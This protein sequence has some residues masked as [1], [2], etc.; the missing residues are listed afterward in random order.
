MLLTF[1]YHRMG[2]VKQRTLSFCKNKHDQGTPRLL[3]KIFQNYAEIL[4][5]LDVQ[6]EKTSDEEN[7]VDSQD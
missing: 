6:E 7:I 2:C 3:T 5:V 1:F 4:R